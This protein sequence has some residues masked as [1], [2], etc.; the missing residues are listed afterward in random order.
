MLESL[1]IEKGYRY[2]ASDL[3][4]SD[5]PYEGGVGFCVADGKDGSIGAAALAAARVAGPRHR[6]RTVLVGERAEYLPIYGG[7]AVRIGD[8]VVGRVR[9]CAY[10][11]TVARNVALATLPPDV[12]EGDEVTVEVLGE[13]VP[14]TVAA[15]VLYDPE[16][17]RLAA[18]DRPH[19]A[20]TEYSAARSQ[21]SNNRGSGCTGAARVQRA[22][23]DSCRCWRAS[24]PYQRAWLPKDVVAGV[25]L[26]ALAIPEVMGYTK[27]AGMPVITGLYTILLPIVVFAVLGFVQAPGR[28]RRL[29]NGGDHVRRH[30]GTG[31]R[32][33][34]QPDSPQVG[35]A[36]RA[37][38]AARGAA[39]AARAARP[40]RVSG[41]LP[42]THGAD[43][44][45]HRR[46]CAG[47]DRAG[48]RD[49]WRPLPARVGARLQRCAAQVLADA[50]AHRLGLVADA[51]W[52]RSPC[53]RS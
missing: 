47:R 28:R 35:R 49:A 10:A 18:A 11:F 24:T 26:A 51:C 14:A 23:I 40:A 5:T 46:R 9:S 32:A 42:L 37:E 30:R 6:L 41:Q 19:A 12:G 15:D 31:D 52:C 22:G 38:R 45:P 20:S 44:L 21:L 16:N 25:T 8:E 36:R 53:S 3:T 13:G 2:F 27:I 33:G 7:E 29:R 4:A 17:R 48:R 34:L 50:R 39:A 43:R 1:R